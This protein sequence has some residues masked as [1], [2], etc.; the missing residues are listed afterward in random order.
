MGGS[1]CLNPQ[2]HNTAKPEAKA[3]PCVDVLVYLGHWISYWHGHTWLSWLLAD[4]AKPCVNTQAHTT[5]HH[6]PLIHWRMATFSCHPSLLSPSGLVLLPFFFWPLLF[7]CVHDWE[8]MQNSGNSYVCPSNTLF[9]SATSKLIH[10]PW[11]Y[12]YL[13][14][15]YNKSPVLFL[16][17]YSR[18]STLCVESLLFYCLCIQWA[19]S[20]VFGLHST[21]LPTHACVHITAL[22]A[23]ITLTS[24]RRAEA[25]TG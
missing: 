5:A 12:C 8:N 9:L 16:H 24:A 22:K 4:M 23:E 20:I 14:Y 25:L 10:S 1:G 11:Y 2:I 18:T 19:S 15:S 7:H 17:L 6:G 13:L 21:L 3:H